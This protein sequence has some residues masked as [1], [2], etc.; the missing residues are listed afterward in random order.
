ML[1]GIVISIASLLGFGLVTNINNN[2][3]FILVACLSR[4]LMGVVNTNFSYFK[5]WNAMLY[6]CLLINSIFLS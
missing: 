2:G 6:T 3:W 5:G 4:L 1:S